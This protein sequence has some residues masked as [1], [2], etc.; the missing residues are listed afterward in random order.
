M[1]E[2]NETV[3]NTKPNNRSFTIQGGELTLEV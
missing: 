1:G 2:I 3:G